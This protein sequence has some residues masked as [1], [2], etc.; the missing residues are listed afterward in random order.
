MITILLL[1]LDVAAQACE[2]SDQKTQAAGFALLG[3]AQ[4]D[5][6]YYDIH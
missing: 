1:Q 6:T 4:A 5:I 2:S 3:Q